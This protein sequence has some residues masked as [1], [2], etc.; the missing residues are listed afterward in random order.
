M[1]GYGSGECVAICKSEAKVD[2]DIARRGALQSQWSALVQSTALYVTVIGIA[3][4][5]VINRAKEDQSLFANAALWT[6]LVVGAFFQACALWI[7]GQMRAQA[8]DFA[9]APDPYKNGWWE[10]WHWLFVG[11]HI[12]C[13][14]LVFIRVFLKTGHGARE[15][16]TSPAGLGINSAVKFVKKHFSKDKRSTNYDKVRVVGGVPSAPAEVP[17]G[18]PVSGKPHFN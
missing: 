13:F 12:L 17:M 18:V 3:L 14:V 7:A 15:T 4:G 5:P 6:C 11:F 10:F 16:W 1:A 8:K 2:R 9:E